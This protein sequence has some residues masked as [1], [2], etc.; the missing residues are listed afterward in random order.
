MN[1]RTAKVISILL[2]PVLMPTYALILIFRLSN[3]LS[4]TT[5]PSVKTALFLIVIFNTLLMPVVISWL[6]L[7]RGLIKSFNM[8]KREERIVPFICNTVLMMIAYYMISQISIPKIFSMLLLGAAASV[9]LAVIINLKWKVSIHMIGVGGITGMF[10]GMS[11]FLLID[12]RIPI[13]ISLL[14]A[15]IIGT[16]R[17]SMGAHKPAQLYVGFLVGFCC[18]Y[19]VLSI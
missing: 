9:V 13:L 5:P 15:G 7:R 12:L 4:Y 6:L 2:H 14:V 1:Y 8:D 18:E 10:F 19:F 3:Y 17:M 16:A 11:T